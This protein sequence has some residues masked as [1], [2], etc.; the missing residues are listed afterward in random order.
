MGSMGGPW[1]RFGSDPV[2][3]RE[4]SRRGDKTAK[5][6]A[7]KRHRPPRPGRG[8]PGRGGR[9][10]SMRMPKPDPRGRAGLFLA[11]PD[12]AAHAALLATHL[13][14]TLPTAAAGHTRSR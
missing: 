12:P 6:D 7:S 14:A 4:Y 11:V 13:A 10:V 9:R 1:R 3:V 5:W 2:A 8:G